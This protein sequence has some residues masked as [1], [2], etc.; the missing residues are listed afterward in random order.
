MTNRKADL[1]NYDDSERTRETHWNS[2][3]TLG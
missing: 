2:D 3:A 1:E